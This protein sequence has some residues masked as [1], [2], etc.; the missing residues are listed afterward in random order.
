[1][2]YLSQYGFTLDGCGG[3]GDGGIDFWG[4]HNMND[5]VIK[6]LGQCKYSGG[7]VVSVG[8]MREWEGVLSR[9]AT[10]QQHVIDGF[11]NM[12][13]D[14]RRYSGGGGWTEIVQQQRQALTQQ[15]QSQ[16]QTQ[17]LGLMVSSQNMSKYARDWFLASPHPMAFSRI[18]PQQHHD[19]WHMPLFMM[20][21]RARVL[22]P[23]LH[24]HSSQLLLK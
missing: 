4:V 20:N 11:L 8:I 22:F 7:R 5:E 17:V 14:D 23:L 15:W 18:Q 9:F 19:G 10:Q 2:G 6:V 24:Q 21:P 3:R 13:N 1:M 16:T 12:R